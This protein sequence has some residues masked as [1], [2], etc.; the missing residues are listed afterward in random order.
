VQH[1]YVFLRSANGYWY[2]VRMDIRSRTWSRAAM[3]TLT[4]IAAMVPVIRLAG[5]GLG[6]FA[7][8]WPILC[9]TPLAMWME[10]RSMT[11]LLAT[12][13]GRRDPFLIAAVPLG[14]AALAGYVL[15]A[16]LF[17]FVLPALLQ[18]L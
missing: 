1:T 12:C 3:L 5:F 7:S 15:S 14:V 9:F 13:R 11:L 4:P 2:A 8:I 16:A 17:A 10:A 6:G 18:I